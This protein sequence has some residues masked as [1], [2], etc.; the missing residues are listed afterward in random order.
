MVLAFVNAAGQ[1]IP[2]MVSFDCKG[3]NQDWTVGEVP[4]TI[5]SLSD[6]GWMMMELF[7]S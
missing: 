4:G 2:P 6:K 5:Y 3:L 7:Y 1:S